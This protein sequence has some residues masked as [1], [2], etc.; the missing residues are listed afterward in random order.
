MAWVGVLLVTSF[1]GLLTAHMAVAV[2]L[3]WRTPRWRG[4]V[5]LL[6]PLAPLAL[7][8][9]LREKLYIRCALWGSSLLLYGVAWA[10]AYL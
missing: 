6:P 3:S 8:W 1:A 5:A 9:A 4:V 10:L 2:G 7:L